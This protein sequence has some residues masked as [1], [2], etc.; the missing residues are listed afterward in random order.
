MDVVVGP[1]A[2]LGATSIWAEVS[3]WVKSRPMR[4]QQLAMGLRSLQMKGPLVVKPVEDGRGG[5]LVGLSEREVPAQ[6][7]FSHS[8]VK[9]MV[10]AR[11]RQA[12]IGA[13]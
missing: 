3:P 11:H 10:G 4:A 12:C 8:T 5:T 9:R 13:R 2:D 7:D 6:S 1:G